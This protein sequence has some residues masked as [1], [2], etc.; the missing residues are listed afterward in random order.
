MDE[1]R[2]RAAT[3]ADAGAF[4]NDESAH[5]THR[6]FGAD[7]IRPDPEFLLYGFGFHQRRDGNANG[8]IGAHDSDGDEWV[9]GDQR[10]GGIE[11]QRQSRYNGDKYGQ[12]GQ[13]ILG[14]LQH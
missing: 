10:N 6:L 2:Q 14:R 9:D 3:H 8:G 12:F 7:D 13:R 4:G 5:A 1:L 11:L